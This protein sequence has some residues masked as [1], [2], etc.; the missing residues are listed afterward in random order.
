MKADFV[1]ITPDKAKDLLAKNTAN[2][3]ANKAHVTRLAKEMLLGRWKCNGDAIRMGNGRLVDGQHRLMAC[4]NSGVSFDTLLV[5][6]LDNSVFDTVD[7]GKKRGGADT[8]AII[9]HKHYAL[10]AAALVIVDLYYQGKATLRLSY[11]GGISN[12][13]YIEMLSKYIALPNSVDH[14]QSRATKLV[15]P[16][17]MTACHYIFSRIDSVLADDFIERLSTGENVAKD[18]PMSKLRERLLQNYTSLKKMDRFH[19]FS[20]VVRAWNH[21]RSGKNLKRLRAI[22]SVDS[23]EERVPTAL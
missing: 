7:T 8:L 6:G 10:M 15:Q 22:Y 19:I 20:M 12:S 16:S 23:K 13:D 14:C 3:P 1:T 5:T 21:E 4:V 18:S 17:I 9:G 11:V 2:R